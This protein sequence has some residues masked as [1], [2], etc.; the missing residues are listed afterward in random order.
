VR[1]VQSA[2]GKPGIKKAEAIKRTERAII[3]FDTKGR[4]KKR[5]STSST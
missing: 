2:T 5:M 3:L 4:Q 1:G